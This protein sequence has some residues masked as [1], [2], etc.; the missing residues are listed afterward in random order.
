MTNP[1]LKSCTVADLM[2]QQGVQV[3]DFQTPDWCKPEI[4]CHPNIPKP[5][6]GIAPRTIMGQKWWDK[7][8]RE[9]YARYDYQ[10][11]ACG[12][13]KKATRKGWLEAHEFWHINYATGECS[14]T[15]IEPLCHTCHNFIH[16]GRLQAIQDQPVAE[17]GKPKDEI[18]RILQHGVNILRKNNLQIWWGTAEYVRD[19]HCFWI[20]DREVQERPK[21]VAPWEAFFLKWKGKTYPGRTKEEWIEQYLKKK[22]TPKLIK[23]IGV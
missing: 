8:R 20:P 9:A 6:H 16:S 1:L 7:T 15:S 13:H 14:I 2:K 3:K 19:L 18:I 21:E 11:V 17:G 4:L 12:I 23:E 10:C 5:L 22:P